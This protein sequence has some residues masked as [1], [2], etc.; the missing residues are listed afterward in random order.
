MHAIH[1]GM[2]VHI[3]DASTQKVEHQEVRDIPKYVAFPRQTQNYVRSWFQTAKTE[4]SPIR[5]QKT[6][7]RGTNLLQTSETEPG[8]HV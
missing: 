2:V 7:T 4:I 1:L 6:D 5:M 3:C 8:K